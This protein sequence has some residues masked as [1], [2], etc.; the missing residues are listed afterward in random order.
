MLVGMIT[1]RDFL[2]TSTMAAAGLAMGACSQPETPPAHTTRSKPADSSSAQTPPQP[3]DAS[4]HTTAAKLPFAISLAQWSLHRSLKSGSM[5][6]LDFPSVARNDYGIEAIEYVNTFFMDKPKNKA[7]LTELRQRCAHQGVESRLI[8][9][10]GLG[11]LGD[12]DGSRRSKAIDNHKPWLHAAKYLGCFAIRVNAAS[13]GS[14]DDQLR[15]AAD[16]L[17]KLAAYAGE[18]DM[19]VIVENHGGLSSNGKWLT[20]V[21]KRADM[22]NLGTLPDF[23]NFCLDWSHRDE[24]DAWYD[25]YQG[26]AEMMPYAKAVSAKSYDFDEQGNETTIDYQRMLKIVTDAGYHSFVG[27]EYEGGRLSEPDGIRATKA[28]LDRIQSAMQTSAQG[29]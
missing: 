3:E 5:T 8:M 14:Y 26:V 20:S 6:N 29:T 11:R 27:I 17:H 16:G 23:G 9:C 21:I 10:D 18:L 12:P 15:F 28:L 7:Y 22:P 2:T 1:R 4:A 24:P 25:R 13:E 19:Q